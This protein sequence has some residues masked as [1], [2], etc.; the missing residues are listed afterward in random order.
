MNY[1]IILDADMM[2][3]IG[4]PQRPDFSSSTCFFLEGRHLRDMM[5]LVGGTA[6]AQGRTC[7]KMSRYAPLFPAE[8]A[9]HSR[10]YATIGRCRRGIMGY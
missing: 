9:A 8:D 3:A 7:L 10:L 5:P 4:R 6:G 1:A 2:A